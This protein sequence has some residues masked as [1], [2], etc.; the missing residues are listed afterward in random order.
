MNKLKELFIVAFQP[1]LIA[2]VLLVVIV[3]MWITQHHQPL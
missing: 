3:S 1:I 2:I